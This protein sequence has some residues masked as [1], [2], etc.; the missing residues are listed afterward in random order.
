MR[1]CELIGE[2]R[3]NGNNG[4]GREVQDMDDGRKEKCCS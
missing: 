3:M 2:R 1:A 4:L